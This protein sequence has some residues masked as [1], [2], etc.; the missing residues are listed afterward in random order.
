MWLA[1]SWNHLH[2]IAVTSV[3]WLSSVQSRFYG[4]I[5]LKN[6]RDPYLYC[7]MCRYFDKQELLASI[8]VY[9]L[10]R[11]LANTA[12]RL[13]ICQIMCTCYLIVFCLY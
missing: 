2:D 9:C 5:G 11:V 4:A 8:I 3:Q 13:G 12:E 6:V 10:K 7:K 1:V